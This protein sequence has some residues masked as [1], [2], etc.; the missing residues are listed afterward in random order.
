MAAQAGKLTVCVTWQANMP[1]LS[2]ELKM[3]CIGIILD[4][5]PSYV[6][7]AFTLNVADCCTRLFYP[8]VLLICDLGL[9]RGMQIYE[10]RMKIFNTCVKFK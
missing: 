3:I 4:L 6:D 2:T 10:T 9:P 7:Y 8:V 1:K 5:Y